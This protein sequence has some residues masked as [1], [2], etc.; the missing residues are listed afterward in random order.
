MRKRWLWA[1]CSIILTYTVSLLT[2]YMFQ[3][4]IIYFSPGYHFQESWTCNFSLSFEYSVR[5]IGE[6]NKESH[7]LR[8]GGRWWILF[9]CFPIFLKSVRG[10]NIWNLTLSDPITNI[11]PFFPILM[12]TPLQ[13]ALRCYLNGRLTKRTIH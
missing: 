4:Y 1:F 7:Q 5:K 6:E 11:K 2:N 13:N 9:I 8:R 10:I 12:K 3:C